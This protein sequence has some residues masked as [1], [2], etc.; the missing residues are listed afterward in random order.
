MFLYHIWN[1]FEK[2]AQTNIVFHETLNYD[3]FVYV[4][5][6]G[7]IVLYGKYK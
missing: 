7:K 3:S 1:E 5:F 6:L 2:R 4:F